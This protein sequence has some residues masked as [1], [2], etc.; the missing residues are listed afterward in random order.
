MTKLKKITKFYF[1]AIILGLA[2]SQTAFAHDKLIEIINN[3]T[4][5]IKKLSMKVDSLEGNISKLKSELSQLKADVRGRDNREMSAKT[6]ITSGQ[7]IKSE[8]DMVV[9]STP[10]AIASPLSAVASEISGGAVSSS[11]DTSATSYVDSSRASDMI[12]QKPVIPVVGMAQEK[13]PEQKMEEEV[14]KVSEDH[15]EIL[16]KNRGI[17]IPRTVVNQGVDP[18]KYSD[19]STERNVEISEDKKAYD[20]ALI[21]MKDSHF[22]EAEQKFSDFMI[23]YPNSGLRDKAGFWYAESFYRQGVYNRAAAEYLNSYKNYPQGA[24]APDALLKLAYSLNAL[25]KKQEACNMLA[26][27][28]KEFP[29]RSNNLMIRSEDAISRMKCNK[30][31]HR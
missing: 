9:N 29:N 23:N 5:Q 16:E 27:L 13:T 6:D 18:S 8:R 11:I 24:K 14:Q 22:K 7:D 31:D 17:K 21:L 3:Q 19:M 20:E 10:E 1:L 30:S 25:N 4:R 28:Q 2:S 12:T 26:K 15:T